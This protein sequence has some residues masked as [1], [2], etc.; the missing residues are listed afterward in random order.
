M[1]LAKSMEDDE[2]SEVF[3]HGLKVR[4]QGE[5]SYLYKITL[6]DASE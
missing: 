1:R 6:D 2:A 4:K 3:E 5:H